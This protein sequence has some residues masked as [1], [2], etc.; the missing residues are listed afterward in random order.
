MDQLTGAFARELRERRTS[1][2]LSQEKLA[3]LAGIHRTY[4]SLLERGLKNPTLHIVFRLADVLGMSPTDFVQAVVDRLTR[5]DTLK[6][7]E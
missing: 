4:V 6:D 2:K 3:E 1:A 7:V 5:E